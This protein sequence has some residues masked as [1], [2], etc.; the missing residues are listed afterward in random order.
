MGERGDD[1]Q[2]HNSVMTGG[3]NTMK[4][5]KEAGCGSASERAWKERREPSLWRKG[6]QLEG[7]AIA[8]VQRQEDARPSPSIWSWEMA[9][10]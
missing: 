9:A 1:K 3:L 4:N 2:S 7:R 6:M 10:P 8:E 5:K